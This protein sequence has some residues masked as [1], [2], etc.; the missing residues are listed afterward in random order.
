MNYDNIIK[1]SNESPENTIIIN[2][3][4]L[5]R[6]GYLKCA[7]TMTLNH[8]NDKHKYSIGLC[9]DGGI[10]IFCEIDCANNGFCD[11]IYGRNLVSTLR[12]RLFKGKHYYPMVLMFVCSFH[13]HVNVDINDFKLSYVDFDQDAQ[14][15]S[16]R[17][18]KYV[19]NANL[20]DLYKNKNI[21]IHIKP[22][23]F[24]SEIVHNDYYYHHDGD[25]GIELT[26]Q[27]E[28]IRRIIHFALI[29]NIVTPNLMIYDIWII[30]YERFMILV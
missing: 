7:K 21:I 9:W 18:D 20:L 28:I 23:Y 4:I 25:Y 30:I 3:E 14:L 12:F 19:I 13:F 26:K 5:E 29:L 6:L 16:E 27:N 8:F 10:T 11:V 1:L 17:Y 2:F 15:S 24:A 22:N